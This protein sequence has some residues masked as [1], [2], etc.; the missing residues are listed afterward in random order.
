MLETN[1]ILSPRNGCFPEPSRQDRDRLLWRIYGDGLKYL[2]E[3][4]DSWFNTNTLKYI[5]K[6][7]IKNFKE[8][9]RTFKFIRN[10]NADTHANSWFKLFTKHASII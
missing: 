6:R 3:E 8:L 1:S 9:D 5:K 7:A 2:L 10:Y 4:P